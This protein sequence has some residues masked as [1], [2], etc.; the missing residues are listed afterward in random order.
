M[1]HSAFS[2][3]TNYELK[4]VTE[5]AP[6]DFIL[7]IPNAFYSKDSLYASLN[8]KIDSLLNEGHLAA[9]LDSTSQ[10]LRIVSAYI[11]VGPQYTLKVLQNG[12]VDA[13]VFEQAR[14]Y[15]LKEGKPLNW[16]NVQQIKTQVLSEYRDQGYLKA[17]VW[18][19][20]V[21]FDNSEVSL[22]L[23]S[24]KGATYTLDSLLVNGNLDV[25][26]SYLK[27]YFSIKDSIPINKKLLSR[28]NNRSAQSSFFELKGSPRFILNEEGDADLVLNLDQI[29]SNEFD[30]IFGFLPNP[31]PQLSS[32]KLLLTGEGSLKLFNPF[33]SGR[34]LAVD[35]KQLQPESPRVNVDFEW[36]FFLDKPLGASGSFDLVKQDSAFVSVTYDIGAQYNFSGDSHL[37]F[38]FNRTNSFLQTIDTMA[39]RINR[40]LDNAIDYDQNLYGVQLRWDKRNNPRNPQNGFFIASKAAV[41]NRE[42]EVNREITGIED[43]GFDFE[44]LYNG[45]NDRKLTSEFSLHGQYFFPIKQRSTILLQNRTG[46]KDYSNFFENDLYRL[47]GLSSVRGVDEQSVLASQY[48]ITTLEY[49]FLLSKESFFSVFSDGAWI[50]DGRAA[51]ENS[52][53]YTGVGSGIDLATKAGIFTLNLAVARDQTTTFDFN[54]SRIHIGYVNRF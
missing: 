20:D 19:D 27:N 33:G 30:L 51:I 8:S 45:L 26:H 38:F 3:Q 29:N 16:T 7:E 32:R 23:Y 49:R 54:R 18:L 1:V 44:T 24:D 34:K 22:K 40:S 28:I 12:N 36:P 42:I 21:Q 17:I 4:V 37:R 13:Q 35:Y 2:Q 39:I 25:K 43:A 50:N 52:N 46:I 47:G 6:P 53:F 15:T 14:K 5:A 9:S 10:E 31:N 41:G 48:S 11:H